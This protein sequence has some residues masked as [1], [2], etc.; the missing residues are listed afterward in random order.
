MNLK[1]ANLKLRQHVRKFGYDTLFLRTPR[2][3]S[4]KGPKSLTKQT[5]EY[6]KQRQYTMTCEQSHDILYI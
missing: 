5:D 6:M 2:M 3:I 1:H 4:S